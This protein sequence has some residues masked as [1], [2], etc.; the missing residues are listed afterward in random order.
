MYIPLARRGTVW[1]PKTYGARR[2]G[3]RLGVF[4]FGDIVSSSLWKAWLEIGS[5]RSL[6]VVS[7][8]DPRSGRPS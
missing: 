2:N 5:D 7:R 4:G 1:M 3:L 6:D 8:T